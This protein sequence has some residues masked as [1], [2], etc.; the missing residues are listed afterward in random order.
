MRTANTVIRLD[1]CPGWSESSLGAQVILLSLAWPG[2]SVGCASAWHAD[3][4]GFNPRIR[5]HSFVEIGHEIISTAI[6]SLPLI[7]IGQLSDLQLVLV[8]RLGSLPRNS[9]VRSTD[10]LDMTIVDWYVKPQIKQTLLLS[11]SCCG[12]IMG[13]EWLLHS[14]CISLILIYHRISNS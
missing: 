7:Q 8:N 5:Q 4:R 6:L 2:S 13:E 3:G 9:V 10:R 11:L 12:S 14:W 1:G